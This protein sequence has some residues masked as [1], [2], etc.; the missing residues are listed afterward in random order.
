MSGR[1]FFICGLLISIIVSATC[2]IPEGIEASSESHDLR[3]ARQLGLYD[4][5]RLSKQMLKQPISEAAF[6][7]IYSFSEMKRFGI[8]QQNPLNRPLL[9]R[10]AAESI[11]RAI[12]HGLGNG[13]IKDKYGSDF[14]Q[15]FQ[16]WI[17]EPKYMSGLNAAIKSGVITGMNNGRFGPDVA[18]KTSDALTLFRRLFNA[19]NKKQ[20]SVTAKKT[21][22]TRK[23]VKKQRRVKGYSFGKLHYAG[24]FAVID[25][26]KFI[27]PTSRLSIENLSALVT[28]I[29]SRHQ[30]QAYLSEL[31]F[32]MSSQNP[33]N[34]AK[35]KHLAFISSILL[36]ALVRV[37]YGT[38]TLYSDVE[39]ESSLFRA[40]DFLGRSGIV[41]GYTDHRFAGDE[42]ITTGETLS[43]MQKIVEQAK[44][45]RSGKR[46][47][48]KD[49]VESFKNLLKSKRARVR[50]ILNRS[51]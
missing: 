39:P 27:D 1:A 45:S 26:N 19:F 22:I 46:M 44:V 25:Q 4:S 36:R 37:E 20:K 6:L 51:R 15:P 3:F 21:I 41:M 29:L 17:I 34:F 30:K 43:V 49:D 32:Y 8:M 18:L 40:L 5:V 35:R 24:A 28:G 48:T 13:M 7:R 12:M 31:K 9:R 38:Y 33:E 10:H 14:F 2:L 47:A 50:R 23:I 11:F 42:Y 16:D